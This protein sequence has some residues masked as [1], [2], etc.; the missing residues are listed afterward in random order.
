MS[1][2]ARM[3]PPSTPSL[4]FLSKRLLVYASIRLREEI[5]SITGNDCPKVRFFVC[6]PRPLFLLL[7]SIHIPQRSC[8]TPVV[9]Q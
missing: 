2:A 1:Q 5:P 8:K 7:E 9:P 6:E 4:P 3:K